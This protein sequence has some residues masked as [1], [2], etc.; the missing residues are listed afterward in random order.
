MT[1]VVVSSEFAFTP[2]AHR[3][4]GFV[5]VVFKAGRV[6]SVLQ[7]LSADEFRGCNLTRKALIL[8]AMSGK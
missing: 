2:H 6:L 1:F 3:V 5:C 4:T 7:Q 8:T